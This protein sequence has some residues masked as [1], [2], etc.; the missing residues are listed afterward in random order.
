MSAVLTRSI[1]FIGVGLC[2]CRQVK[3]LMDRGYEG[4][5]LNTS[6]TDFQ[7]IGEVPE[8]RKYKIPDADGVDKNRELAL[9]LFGNRLEEISTYILKANSS[10]QHYVFVFSAGGGSGSGGSPALAQ[11]FGM[12]FDEEEKGK[13]VSIIATLPDEKD[14]WIAIN[15]AKACIRDIE[16]QCDRIKSKI[17]LDNSQMD[18]FSINAQLVDLIDGLMN[19]PNV[20]EEIDTKVLER[21]GMKQ[22]DDKEALALWRTEGCVNMAIINQEDSNKEIVEPIV[23]MPQYNKRP[24]KMAVSISKGAKI[25]APLVRQELINVLGHNGSDI[26]SGH[27]ETGLSYAYSFGLKAPK[28]MMDKLDAML[29]VIKNCVAKEDE[30]EEINFEFESVSVTDIFGT[31]VKTTTTTKGSLF[32]NSKGSL[33]GKSTRF[34]AKK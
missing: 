12:H 16:T 25:D 24:L 20:D 23:F 1:I 26:K 8:H 17:Y 13:T 34:G 21:E 22:S 4:F 19:L 7:L 31:K 11:H 9:E 15:N 18:K 27:N 30:G 28:S 2:G 33:F 29:T 14:G 6:E 5:L 32:G 10:F 3:E